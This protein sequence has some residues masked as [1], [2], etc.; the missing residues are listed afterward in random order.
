LSEADRN[1]SRQLRGHAESQIHLLTNPRSAMEGD[2]YSYRYFASEG[3][4]PGYNFPRL[5]LSAFIP[6]RRGLR[7][8]D[9][10]LSRPRFLAISEFGPR[11]VIYHEGARYRIHKVSLEIRDN[12][13]EVA[14][15]S[16]RICPECG[17][18]HHVTQEPG[19]EVCEAC[20]IPFGTA[21]R[22]S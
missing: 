21:D 4:L 12:T 22:V 17:Y 20:S 16:M 5:P 8:K 2:F 11:A 15:T 13:Q 1:K 19:P 9:E 3:F 6:A 14:R 10:F 18:G 7:G